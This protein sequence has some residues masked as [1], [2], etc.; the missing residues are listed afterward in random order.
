MFANLLTLPYRIAVCSRLWVYQH[1]WMKSHRLPRPVVSVGNLTVGG[2]GKTP[3]T[4]WVAQYLAARGKKV[5]ILSR[6]YRRQSKERCLL[7]SNG[8]NILG[9]PEDAGDEPFL[10]ATRCPGVIVA[11]GANR[12]QLGCWVLEQLAV[13]C[14]V[15]D[16]GFQHVKLER[17]VNLLLV[18]V[19]DSA[20]IQSLLPVGR[21]REPLSGAQRATSVIFTRVEDL[22][23]MESMRHGLER[24]MGKTVSPIA[25]RFEAE[26]LTSENGEKVHDPSWLKGKRVLIFSGVANASSF[27]RMVEGQGAQVA[28]ELTF[29]DH[30]RYTN[31]TLR[32]VQAQAKKTQAQVLVTTEKDMVKV[33]PLWAFTDPVWALSLGIQFLKG[34][35]RLEAQLQSIS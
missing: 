31:E 33:Q 32:Q 23:E 10:M 26:R 2:T 21:L 20:G 22:A 25:M 13:D 16:D 12:F 6:G 34:Q 35:D 7:V 17:D 15:L 5:A 19:S 28:D 3:M 4:M 18:D 30:M 24:A 11:V 8:K 14:F 27:R 1:G 9:S 29:P